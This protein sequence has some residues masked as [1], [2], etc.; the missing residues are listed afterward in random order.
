MPQSKSLA[1]DAKLA[2][3][4]RQADERAS[5]RISNGHKRCIDGHQPEDVVAYNVTSFYDCK[6]FLS[7]QQ[8]YE[9]YEEDGRLAPFAEKLVVFV[10]HAL[11]QKSLSKH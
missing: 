1:K 3:F 11:D 6:R 8:I 10:H 4:A 2:W 9:S 7:G 5:V